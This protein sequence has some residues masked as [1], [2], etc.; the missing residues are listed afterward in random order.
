MEEGLECEF[1]EE[2][3]AVHLYILQSTLFI[4]VFCLLNQLTLGLSRSINTGY[5]A[6]LMVSSSQDGPD[7]AILTNVYCMKTPRFSSCFSLTLHVLWRPAGELC[8]SK[9]LKDI[10]WEVWSQYMLSLITKARKG[11]MANCTLAC[12]APL[13][14]DSCL[15]TQISSA[16][17]SLI[18]TTS[19][20]I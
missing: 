3:E 16:K 4:V 2:K 10:G 9:S 1:L 5:S 6:D 19:L 15:S 8:S 14:S 12:K 7:Y 18:I 13:R 17:V 11:N 20:W